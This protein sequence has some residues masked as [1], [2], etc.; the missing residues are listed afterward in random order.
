MEYLAQRKLYTKICK[1]C[2]YCL[3]FCAWVVVWGTLDKP[4]SN[5]FYYTLNIMLSA[6]VYNEPEPLTE[7]RL[8]KNGHLF[9]SV[10]LAQMCQCCSSRTELHIGL[11]QR[12]RHLRALKISE[13]WHSNLD[14]LLFRIS[15]PPFF[16]HDTFTLLNFQFCFFPIKWSYWKVQVRGSVQRG[17][18]ISSTYVHCYND[19]LKWLYWKKC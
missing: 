15:C 8:I 18:A 5:F 14:E 9:P 2:W 1:K 19:L 6:F 13:T 11:K 17:K 4:S 3:V 10:S 12:L 7:F 16:S